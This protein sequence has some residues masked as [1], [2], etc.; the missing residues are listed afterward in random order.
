MTTSA[1]PMN[2]KADLEVPDT[3]MPIIETKRLIIRL[4]KPSDLH[5]FY[6]YAKVPGVGEAAGWPHHTSIDES[7]QILKKFIEIDGNYAIE[8]KTNHKVIGSIGLH[9]R[10][11]LLVQYA[12][13]NQREVGYVL[14]KTYWGQ[15]LMTE[16]VKAMIIY[17][18]ETMQLDLLTVGHFTENAKSQR[19]IEKNHFIYE[20]TGVYHSNSLKKDF[21]ELKYVLTKDVFISHKD[22][23]YSVL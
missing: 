8:L 17:G 9:I 12:H 3:N 20:T 7:S 14:S 1:M 22:D 21:D 10:D 18:F 4:W 23:F 6:H 11:E 15:G 2:V 13:L 16:A 5:D 19:V